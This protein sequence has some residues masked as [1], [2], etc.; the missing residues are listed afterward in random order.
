MRSKLVHF[1]ICIILILGLIACTGVPVASPEEIVQG[2]YQAMNQ[3]G[4]ES[5]MA[6]VADGIE[7]RGHCYITG[8][9]AFRTFIQGNIDHGDQF[10]ISGLVV[11]GDEV[12]FDYVIHRAE[13]VL[14]R[15]VDSVMRVRDGKIIYFEL[16]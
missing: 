14:A 16:N 2:F 3:G 1:T 15:G 10:E 4:I 6:F 11:D 9:D 7:C 5:A 12:T 8:S 13:S